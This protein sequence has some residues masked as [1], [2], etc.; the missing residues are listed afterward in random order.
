MEV[1][2]R[3]GFCSFVRGAGAFHSDTLN[4]EFLSCTCQ[5]FPIISSYINNTLSFFFFL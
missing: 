2:R 5:V 3:G 4:P 1:V